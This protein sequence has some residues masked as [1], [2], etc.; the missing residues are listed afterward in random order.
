MHL[1]FVSILLAVVS[2]GIWDTAGCAETTRT[3]NEFLGP[4]RSVTIKKLVYSATEIYDRAGYLIEAAIDLPSLGMLRLQLTRG[5][6][7]LE[8]QLKRKVGSRSNGGQTAF[9][10]KRGGSVGRHQSLLLLLTE[11]SYSDCFLDVCKTRNLRGGLFELKQSH[12]PLTAEPLNIWPPD[13]L[14][15]MKPPIWRRLAC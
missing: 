3:T 15:M 6:H 8:N 4:I 12:F 5:P 11:R 1:R 14:K 2:G 9:T 13:W 7:V 10:A